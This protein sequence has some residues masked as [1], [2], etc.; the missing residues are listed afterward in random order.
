MDPDQVDADREAISSFFEAHPLYYDG[1][2]QPASVTSWLHDME[3][4]FRLCHVEARLQISLAS[5]C[6]VE[7]ARMWW[8]TMGERALPDRTWVDFCAL[9]IERF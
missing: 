8:L 5:R 6:L 7:D 4:I 3:L 1:T 9:M 2:R